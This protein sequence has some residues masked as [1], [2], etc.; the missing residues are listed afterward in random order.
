[1][2]SWDVRLK[3]VQ[4]VT[5]VSM[6]RPGDTARLLTLLKLSLQTFTED[7]RTRVNLSCPRASKSLATRQGG[8]A[9]D[10]QDA[11]GLDEPPRLHIVRRRAGGAFERMFTD[12]ADR[13]RKTRS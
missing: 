13:S 1:M 9:D 2:S 3:L 5:G 6:S 4:R 8:D 12:L 10:P 7:S 11:E